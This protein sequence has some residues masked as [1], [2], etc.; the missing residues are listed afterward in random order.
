[1]KNDCGKYSSCQCFSPDRAG[2]LRVVK[3][4]TTMTE[5]MVEQLR[6]LLVLLDSLRIDSVMQ[7]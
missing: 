2:N 5:S 1:M 7:F 3:G 4:I 6:E